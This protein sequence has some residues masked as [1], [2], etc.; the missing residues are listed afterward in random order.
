V[1]DPD[2]TVPILVKMRA[3]LAARL[4]PEAL[5]PL[6]YSDRSQFVREAIA[7]KLGLPREFALMKSRSGVGGKPT[8]KPVRYGP[9]KPAHS[10]WNEPPNSAPAPPPVPGNQAL[11]TDAI[12]RTT[13]RPQG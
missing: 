12:R 7:E 5:R 10:K 1:T 8:H 3:A 13:R 6:G 11:D 2:A 9:H 4:E